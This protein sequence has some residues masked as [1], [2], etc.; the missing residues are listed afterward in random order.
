MKAVLL[1]LVLAA[2]IAPAVRAE[3]DQLLARLEASGCRFNRNGSWYPAAEAKNHLLRK[4]EYFEERSNVQ[5]A[6]QFIKRAASRSS[7]SGQPYLVQCA[8]AAPVESGAWL[9][10]RLQEIRGGR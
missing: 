6:E 5:S 9:T 7:V 2:P 10:L 8:T 4:L 3:I 1:A